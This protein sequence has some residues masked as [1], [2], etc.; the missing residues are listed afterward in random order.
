[1]SGVDGELRPRH[2]ICPSA[3]KWESCAGC[4]H[5]AVHNEMVSCKPNPCGLA[6][7]SCQPV[8]RA[9][10]ACTMRVADPVAQR[11]RHVC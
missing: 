5:R 8:S 4:A 11:F 3:G 10:E 1:M 6:G 2:M 9:N 7:G